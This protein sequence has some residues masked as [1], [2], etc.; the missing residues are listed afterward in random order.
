VTQAPGGGSAPWP[1]R[2]V[3]DTQ[4]EMVA[5]LSEP[6]AYPPP[7]D[8]VE[9]VETHISWVFL[10]GNYAYK[11]KKPL[12]LGFL[13]FRDRARRLHYCQEELRLNSR[14]A[15]EIY[16]DVVGARAT[17]GGWRIGPPGDDAEPAVRMRRFPADARLDRRLEAG[18]LEAEALEDFAAELARFQRGLPPAEPG[19]GYGRAADVT[20]PALANFAALPR[21]GLDRQSATALVTLEDWTREQ[22]RVLAGQ[23]DA[24][25]AAGFVRECHGDLH[26]AN[27]V[28][29]DGRIAA[30]DGIEFDPAL[31][32]ID[33]QSEVAFLLMD[34]ESR[35]RPDLG[36]RFCNA[37][38]AALGDY[39]G[40]ALLGWYLVYRHL[41][42]AKID[43]I[44]LAQAD[45]GADEAKR[46]RARQ[47]SHIRLAV[48][49]AR[50]PTP[51]L[52]LMHGLSGS[53]K[54]YLARR[55]APL[56]PAA[57]IRSDLERK[58][59]HGLDPDVAAPAG[60]GK[61]LYDEASSERTYARLEEIAG[62]AL[63][64]G[65]SVIVDAAFLDSE[66]RDRFT[67][68]AIEY[69]ARPVVLACV[70]P[71]EV[72]RERIVARRGDPSDAGLDVL[73]EQLARPVRLGPL[74]A[75]Y[76]VVVDTSEDVDMAALA[77]GL[78]K[79]VFG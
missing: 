76:R 14:L 46:L 41:V 18:K 68:L 32:W 78:A 7:V 5:A 40:L 34:L 27:L 43:G 45:L 28:M 54:S 21:E 49:H 8:R 9:L 59:L 23:F 16:L 67:A 53:G 63:G 64:A 73:E 1:E 57:W 51:L 30:F 66:R 33:L 13:D 77:A 20:R 17:P 37:W 50:P 19:T 69:G 38:L 72:L 3:P 65:F 62:T 35:G 60:I 70:A 44:R 4:R 47:S 42:R 22:A 15:P 31:R 2:A 52:V 39:D 6:G 11:F 61:G 55:L 26:L 25:L 48:R 74:E 29:L 75:K 79:R 12:D 24:R 71:P 58:R 36:W 10:A 56:L